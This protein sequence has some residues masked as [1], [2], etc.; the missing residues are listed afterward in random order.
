MNNKWK[1]LLY[2]YFL[3]FGVVMFF[4]M[5]LR[6]V[7]PQVMEPD[8]MYAMAL[9]LFVNRA[10]FQLVYRQNVP[11]LNFWIRRILL[12]GQAAVTTPVI[13]ILFGCVEPERYLWYF[14]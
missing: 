13:F 1:N 10:V 2:S 14:I 9:S 4:L 7:K 5:F 3:A 6:N 8:T 12:I 11:L